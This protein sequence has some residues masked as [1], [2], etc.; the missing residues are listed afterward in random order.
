M[1]ET[2]ADRVKKQIQELE[3]EIARTKYNKATQFHVGQLKA[4]LAKLRDEHVKRSEKKAGAGYSVKKGGDATVILVGFPSVGKS[5]ILNKLTNAESKVGHYD[6]TTLDI[7]PGMMELNHA[8]IQLLDIPGLISGVSR[9]KGR[10]RE[11]L[12]VVRNADLVVFV[13]EARKRGQ[14]GVLREELYEAG[15]RL[16]Q[17][18]PDVTIKKKSGGGLDIGSAVKLTRMSLDEASSIMR[19]FRI[20]NAE[21]VIRSDIT[22]EQFIDCVMGNRVYMP[23]LTVINKTDLVGSNALGEMRK[24][25]GKC[26]AISA[27]KGENLDELRE[28]IWEKIGLIRIY[29]KRI[30][31]NPDM[32][33]PLIMSRGS[34]IKDVAEKIHHVFEE[35]F[36]FARVWGSSK[37]GGQK[38]GMDYVLMDEDIVEFHMY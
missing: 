2:E 34:T 33:E 7:I 20:L 9:G 38:L 21:V 22:A 11:I 15:F 25:A 30:G 3:D 13:L 23:S 16:D 37:F 28:A 36:R 12:S 35:R 18:P 26:I 17:E 24:E 5:T 6:F 1:A 8:L 29:L 4:K 32:D 19:E 14:I 27:E 31:K 10:G